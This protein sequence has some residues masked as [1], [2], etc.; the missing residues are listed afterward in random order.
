MQ[1]LW[2]L[3]ILLH[4]LVLTG[5]QRKPSKKRAGTMANDCDLSIAMAYWWYV[6]ERAMQH[7]G[8]VQTLVAWLLD[9]DRR[10][11]SEARNLFNEG[12]PYGEALSEAR[13][14]K[15][16]V[17]WEFTNSKHALQEVP[18]LS[19]SLQRQANYGQEPWMPEKRLRP[20][21]DKT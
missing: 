20:Q 13:E 9:R 21:S 17:L 5:T 14:R 8:L 1:V 4:G 16:A 19:E 3:L 2:A 12:W 18:S 11:R 6:Y 7:P 15:L 10:A